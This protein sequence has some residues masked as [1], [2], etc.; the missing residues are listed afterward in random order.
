MWRKQPGISQIQ[1]SRI[2][3]ISFIGSDV[4]LNDIEFILSEYPT[5]YPKPLDKNNDLK[6]KHK[7][8]YVDKI[9][10]NCEDFKKSQSRFITQLKKIGANP[11]VV[12]ASIV[13]Y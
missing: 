6:Q 11:Q 8:A 5:H 2:N 1:I 12:A 9:D 13:W 7:I 4:D 3:T 10:I